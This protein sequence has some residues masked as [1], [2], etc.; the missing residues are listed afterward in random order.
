V[1]WGSRKTLRYKV[2][3][4][5][6]IYVRA[7]K[8]IAGVRRKAERVIKDIRQAET[9]FPRAE[10][11]QLAFWDGVAPYVTPMNFRL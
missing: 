6:L 9:V 4:G 10:Y 2:P 7:L 11:I 8:V 5:S 3:S 1:G